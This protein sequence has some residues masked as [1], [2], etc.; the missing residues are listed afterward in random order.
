MRRFLVASL[1]AAV[2]IGGWFAWSNWTGGVAV[3]ADRARRGDIQ[4]FVDEEGKTRLPQTYLVT[5]PYPGRIAAIELPEG[6]PVSQGQVVARIMPLD[7]D[8]SLEAA[9]AAVDKA[10]AALVESADISVEET[11]LRQTEKYV[12]SMVHTVQAADKR[13]ESGRAKQEYAEKFLARMTAAH[14]RDAV[15]DDTLDQAEVRYVEGNVDY[16]QDVLVHA[17]LLA[18]KAA[19]DLMP[20]TVNQYIARKQLTHA[21]KA[22]ELAQAQVQLKEARRDHERGVMTSPIEGIV[23]ARTETDERYLGAGA[24]LLEIGRLEELEVEADVLS[25]DAVVLERG[26]AVDIYG[27]AIGLRPVRG[28]VDRIYPAGFTKVSS[29]GV[30]QQRVKVIVRFEPRALARLGRELGVGYRVNVK[31]YTAEAKGALMVPRSALFRG[32]GGDWQVFAVR[33]GRAR[34]IGVKVGL[35]NDEAAEIIDGLAEEEIVV[36]APETNL[37]DGTR[38]S[39]V[40]RDRRNH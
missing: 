2:V 5:M 28:R 8:L 19:T 12:E 36:L 20:T 31:I 34:L 30:E 7:L 32:A 24:P 4:E 23:L 40:L 38:V 22:H 26:A 29:L 35:L 16:Q 11:A 39:P 9:Q 17:A 14:Q 3:E 15:T 25:Q 6:T 21:V 37:E 10:Q 1:T 13:V 18:M 33:G 27:P